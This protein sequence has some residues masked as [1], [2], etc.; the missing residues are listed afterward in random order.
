MAGFANIAIARYWRLLVVATAIVWPDGGAFAQA[1]AAA[2]R[3]CRLQTIGTGRVGAGTCRPGTKP[4]GAG[5]AAA[6]GAK[7]WPHQPASFDTVAPQAAQGC[8]R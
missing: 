2:G 4:V 5:T 1:G 7:H 3:I 6:T 8:M